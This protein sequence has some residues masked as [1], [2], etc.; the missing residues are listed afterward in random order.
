MLTVE[1]P[2]TEPLYVV[3]MFCAA[4]CCCVLL[5]A[6]LLGAVLLCAVH[7]W[8]LLEACLVGWSSLRSHCRAFRS[9]VAVHPPTPP[10]PPIHHPP[11]HPPRRLTLWVTWSRHPSRW[12][13]SLWASS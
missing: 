10:H 9:Q 8:V 7:C 11:T 12:R 6:V 4:V 1:T 2:G 13:R 3:V 5:C